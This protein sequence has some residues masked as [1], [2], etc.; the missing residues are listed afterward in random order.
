MLIKGNQR[1]VVIIKG[2]KD[3]PYEMACLFLR[4]TEER[5]SGD[6]LKDAE[7]IICNAQAERICL[8]RRRRGRFF[9]IISF[10][11]G[12]ILGITLSVGIYLLFLATC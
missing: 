4:E 8:S 3:S 7:E 12:M 11:S 6:I 5:R 2:K 10:L 9:G 1:R